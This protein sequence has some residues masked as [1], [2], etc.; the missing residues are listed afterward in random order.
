MA[1]AVF[2]TWL[3][4]IT[5]R[6]TALPIFLLV[7]GT[8]FALFFIYRTPHSGRSQALSLLLPTLLYGLFIFC[9]SH[10]S[11][12]GISPPFDTNL[13]HPVE[14]ATL[15]IFLCWNWQPVLKKKGVFLF[16]LGVFST[17][18]LYGITDEIHQSFIP[19]RDASIVDLAMDMV[20]TSVGCSLF[21]GA[22][23]LRGY[24]ERKWNRA[25]NRK[26]KPE[27]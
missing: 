1:G 6:E 2:I 23:H 22:L 20:G 13:F 10:T 25:A 14:Y 9:L 21:L 27:R 19:G 8:A 17:G 4:G 15:G 18:T 3:F 12:E 24:V 11:Y 5:L 26:P 7:L 16:F